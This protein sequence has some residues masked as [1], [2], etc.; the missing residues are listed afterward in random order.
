LEQLQ[1]EK[2]CRIVEYAYRHVPYYKRVFDQAG[3]RPEELRADPGS[4][5]KIPV[6]TKALL[7]ENYNDLSTTEPRRRKELTIS[8]T[9]GSTGTPMRFMLD[10]GFRDY[11]T[12]DLQRHLGWAGWKLGQR[13]AYIWG[14]NFEAKTQEQLRTRLLDW[15]WNR[16]LT[17]A[18]ALND[19][20][21]AAFATPSVVF[22]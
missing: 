9:G 17:N 22:P 19:A 20:C 7:R 4:F 21:L 16:F 10:H 12:A 11:A 8:T 6:L 15:T 18:Y 14:T 2:L 3:F 1:W 5:K 13:H